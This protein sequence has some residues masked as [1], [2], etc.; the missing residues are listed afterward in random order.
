[1]A[2]GSLIVPSEP[3]IPK[4]TRF[5]RSAASNVVPEPLTVH[6]ESSPELARLRLARS[7]GSPAI[8]LG[9]GSLAP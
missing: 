9:I 8:T 1:M 2:L 5:V 3:S 7:I 4:A 6:Q